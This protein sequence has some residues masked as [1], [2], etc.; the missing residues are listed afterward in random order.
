MEEKCLKET[1]GQPHSLRLEDE[2]ASGE[3]RSSQKHISDYAIIICFYGRNRED[4][5]K[6]H[7]RGPGALQ[8][9]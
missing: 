7:R 5:L 4:N 9:V 1:P 3:V 6:Q 8:K 2:C